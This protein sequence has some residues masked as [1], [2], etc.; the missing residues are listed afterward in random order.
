MEEVTFGPL[1]GRC[2]SYDKAAGYGLIL[3]FRNRMVPVGWKTLGDSL[4]SLS[5]HDV[6]ELRVT[7]EG[8][9]GE[10]YILSP[11]TLEAQAHLW[12]RAPA[13]SLWPSATPDLLRFGRCIWYDEGLRRGEILCF[14]TNVLVVA[15][16]PPVLR[17]HDVVEFRLQDGRARDVRLL[18]SD[19]VVQG[20]TPAH[21]WP[22][23]RSNRPAW[24]NVIFPVPLDGWFAGVREL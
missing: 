18:S 20:A 21:V 6:V 10:V 8:S 24:P 15:P 16:A 22:T 3:C 12:L 17:R 9:A 13:D 4:A 5:L 2:V 7:R 1:F 23:A 19:K 11:G 14:T